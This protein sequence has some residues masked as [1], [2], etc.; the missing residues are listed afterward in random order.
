MS[1]STFFVTASGTDIGKTYVTTGLIRA[2]LSAGRKVEAL[3]PLI[4]DFT[5]ATQGGSDTVLILQALDKEPIQHAIE[6]VSPWRYTAALAPDMAAAREGLAVPYDDVITYCRDARAA[7]SDDTVL[8]VEGAGGVL[9]PVDDTHTM[10]D[11]MTDLAATPILVVGSYLGT[12]SHTLTALEAL[13]SHGLIPA[14][15]VVSESE[16]AGIPLDE[17]CDAIKRFIGDVPLVP[18]PRGDQDAFSRLAALISR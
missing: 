17:T 3:K 6:H 2:L 13:Q 7:L 18:V 15:I 4:T 14:A 16:G 5:D 1:S 11:F 8:I 12:I 10:R 9:V